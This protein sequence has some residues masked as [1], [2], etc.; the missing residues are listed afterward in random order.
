MAYISATG[1]GINIK[2]RRER[3]HDIYPRC[4]MCENSTHIYECTTDETTEI[5]EES[6]LDIKVNCRPQG[7]ALAIRE[8]I[9]KYQEK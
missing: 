8:L 7:M 3:E 1:T 5:F 6:C 2:H 4:A 9:G